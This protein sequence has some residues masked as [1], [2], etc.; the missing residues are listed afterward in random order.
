[1]TPTFM[2]SEPV[3]ARFGKYK[4]TRVFTAEEEQGYGLMRALSVDE[5]RQAKIGSDLPSELLL[6]AFEDN[7][8]MDPAGLPQRAASVL[9]RCWART[10]G[11]CVR[12]TPKS[13]PDIWLA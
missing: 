12:V 3:L 4:G 8:Q 7:R 6:G 11:A 10:P 9:S 2:G 13:L 5:R 1:M